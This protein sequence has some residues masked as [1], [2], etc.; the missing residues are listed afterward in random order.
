MAGKT[1]TGDVLAALHGALDGIGRLAGRIGEEATEA[2]VE[3]IFQA[4]RVFVTGKGRSGYVA[5]CFAMRLMQ[6]GFDAHV[7]GEATCPRIEAPDL[8]I[9]VSCSGTT[10]TTVQMARIAAESGATVI[11]VTADADSELARCAGRRVL[12]PVRGED[13]QR[14]YR[15]VIGPH[16]NTLFE[17]TLLLYFDALVYAILERGH[18]PQDTIRQR[19]TNLE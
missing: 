9:A 16:N 4:Q 8:L 2:L 5:R 7:P 14:S 19:H 11:A 6:M 13:V 17:E 10:V 15:S 18:I 3:G 12:I 1:P